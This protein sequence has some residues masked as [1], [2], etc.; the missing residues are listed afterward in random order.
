MF[1]N[2]DYF[3]IDEIH[4][5]VEKCEGCST[6]DESESWPSTRFIENL[7]KENV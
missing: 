5:V 6:K 4:W 7:E 1:M 2:I 3:T